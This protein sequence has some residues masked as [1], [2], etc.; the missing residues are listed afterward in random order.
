[1]SFRDHLILCIIF[2][3]FFSPYF[4][5]S[6]TIVSVCAFVILRILPRYIPRMMFLR[7]LQLG[8][9]EEATP[10]STVIW[11]PLLRD[12]R[13]ELIVFAIAFVKAL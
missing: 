13:F 12:W 9:D 10:R 5:N 8:P 1:M 7:L 4:R 6:D 3:V 2:F 11:P